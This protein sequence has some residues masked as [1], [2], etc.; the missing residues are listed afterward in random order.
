MKMVNSISLSVAKTIV[1]VGGNLST[2]V[3]ANTFTGTIADIDFDGVADA[4]YMVV[5]K[6]F[7][8]ENKWIEF[9]SACLGRFIKPHIVFVTPLVESPKYIDDFLYAYGALCHTD[10]VKTYG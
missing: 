9:K 3:V 6:N 1:F 7:P 4:Y 5:A 8:F 2:L 10:G